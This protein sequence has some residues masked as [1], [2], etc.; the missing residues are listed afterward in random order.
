MDIRCLKWVVAAV[1]PAQCWPCSL[2]CRSCC[3]PWRTYSIWWHKEQSTG[4]LS[5]QGDC[6][7]VEVEGTQL[8]LKYAHWQEVPIPYEHSQPRCWHEAAVIPEGELYIH[9]GLTQPFYITRDLL[10]DHA[11]EMV[12]LRFSPPSLQRLTIEA[13][14][15]LDLQLRSHWCQLPQTLQHILKT[16]TCPDRIL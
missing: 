16:R 5:A 11:E 12:V 15:G 3:L 4:S 2:A 6:W 8:G 9:S 7:M 1:S 13:V 10:T 14:C